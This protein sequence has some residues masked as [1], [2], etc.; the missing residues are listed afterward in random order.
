MTQAFEPSFW[1]ARFIKEIR[2]NRGRPSL[3]R[4]R[5]FAEVVEAAAPTRVAAAL[6]I[7]GH[8]D[9]QV[10]PEK[11]PDEEWL[12]CLSGAVTWLL[13]H[14]MAQAPEQNLALARGAL[15]ANALVARDLPASRL[16]FALLGAI[17]P[18]IAVPAA[19]RASLLAAVQDISDELYRT[20]EWAFV[21]V[22]RLRRLCG[23]PAAIQA[24]DQWGVDAELLLRTLPAAEQA[25]WN[26]AIDC[27]RRLPAGKASDRWR[28][29]FGKVAA[30][31][32]E[33][34][35]RLLE[36]LNLYSAPARAG[37]YRKFVMENWCGAP[38][39]LTHDANEVI[40]RGLLWGLAGELDRDSISVLGRVA[41]QGY[42]KL[43]DGWGAR[44]MPVGNT[45][46]TILAESDD[47]LAYGQLVRIRDTVN[48]SQPKSKIEKVLAEV[49][50]KRNLDPADLEEV[51]V[52]EFELNAEGGFERAWEGLRAVAPV[53][54]GRT[55]LLWFDAAGKALTA[56][57]AE[58][59]KRLARDIKAFEKD[60]KECRQ[61][62]MVWRDRFDDWMRKPRTWT[63]AQWRD[64][65]LS[66][67]LL[68][69]LARGL[70]W[71]FD[72][73][74]TVQGLATP[75]G[76]VDR[77]AKQL[78]V[79][80]GARVTLWHP[81]ES[82]DEDIAGWRDRIV[83]MNVAQ[84]IKQVFREVYRPDAAE[85]KSR[86]AGRLVRQ[87]QFAVLTKQ[88]GWTFHM[89]GPSG[90]YCRPNHPTRK[91]GK[92]EARL[93]VQPFEKGPLTDSCYYKYL[94]TGAARVPRSKDAAACREYSEAMRDIDLF[95]SVC[96]VAT[97]APDAE[98]DAVFRE[99]WVRTS[100]ALSVF[101]DT[102]R[103]MLERRLR[104][105]SIAERVRFDGRCVIVQGEKDR[106][107]LHLGT[108][109]AYLDGKAEPIDFPKKAA[110]TLEL[111]GAPAWFA[112]DASVIELFNK[113]VLLAGDSAIKDKALRKRLGI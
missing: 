87:G 24:F 77:N 28:G 51:T 14:V 25:V 31:H 83:A 55:A 13:D 2:G 26:D 100:D 32:A 103:D 76:I 101:G 79:A 70:V 12:D 35:P 53:A 8:I 67:S 9:T 64:R 104:S 41:L 30:R 92:A 23:E 98:P 38:I 17:D 96:A 102:R 89:I 109:Q 111:P 65:F 15:A 106:Y 45:A 86:F 40:L 61:I 84:P 75:E 71:T 11:S 66:H 72:D 82:A 44:S 39:Y 42:T 90:E 88:R 21:T 54:P 50:A 63:Y 43:R 108:G 18:A 93:D 59:K 34:R 60:A 46:I 20:K 47:A 99:Y 68:R 49:A 97:D 1:L 29:E 78:T 3:E 37:T 52:P 4:T 57:P 73:R 22:Q 36:L 91:L 56:P 10:A 110:D 6:A 19:E 74:K 85:D 27:C 16:R 48:Y 33:F 80:A 95:A 69:H 5:S 105:S 62:Y 94:L 107:R 112:G 81:V 7:V 113:A 58:A